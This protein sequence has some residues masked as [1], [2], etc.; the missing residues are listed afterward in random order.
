MALWNEQ[1]IGVFQSVRFK[2]G[3][4]NS[5]DLCD[6]VF[7]L[8]ALEA[9]IG[10]GEEQSTTWKNLNFRIKKYLKKVCF[11]HSNKNHR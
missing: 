5:L 11:P 1:Q 3:A 8:F 6:K 7:L 10:G 9:E 2:T 4:A